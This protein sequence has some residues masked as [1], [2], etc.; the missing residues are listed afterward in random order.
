MQNGT[1][2]ELV[3]YKK[4]KIKK[5]PMSINGKQERKKKGL[6]I[7]LHYQT[8]GR[9]LVMSINFVLKRRQYVPVLLKK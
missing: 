1:C 6:Y 3:I 4:K 9:C 2:T 8:K 5:T 7:L